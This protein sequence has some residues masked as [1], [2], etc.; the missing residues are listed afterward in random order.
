[1]VDRDPARALDELAELHAAGALTDAEFTAARAEVTGRAAA[2]PALPAVVLPTHGP[3]PADASARRP[4]RWGRPLTAL[5]VA[6]VLVAA[7][8]LIGG[9]FGLFSG[10]GEIFLEATEGQG[11]DPFT[12]DSARRSST[13]TLPAPAD[14]PV[15]ADA[16]GVPSVRGGTPGIYG[17][18]RDTGQ[19]DRAQIVGF[20]A[21][22]PEK[23]AAWAGVQGITVD[24]IPA[25]VEQLTPTVLLQDT[26]V[27]N[28]GFTDGRAT[29]RQS[30]LQAGTAVLVDDRGVPRVRCACGNPLVAP[31][32][33]GV[34]PRYQNSPWN[35]FS[36]SRLSVIVPQETPVDVFTLVD[37]QTG[38]RFDRPRGSDGE[39]DA[40]TGQVQVRLTWRGTAD[41][42]LYVT[43]PDGSTIYY[44]ASSSPSGGTLDVDANRGCSTGAIGDQVNIENVYWPEESA[45]IGSYG[46]SASLYSECEGPAPTYQLTVTVGGRVVHDQTLTYDYTVP[47]IYFDN[48]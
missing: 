28:H 35:G 14:L 29:P 13:T 43:E 8:L 4:V 3:R 46:A 23:A 12:P 33:T 47:T 26:R 11:G 1:M 36:E 6:L 24:G 45:P 19:C 37:L 9:G 34:T 20:L 39:F 18:D 16:T 27:T 38:E 48:S 21:G 42:D 41:L 15:A 40:R 32:P 10:G 30:V 22:E 5:A 44:G 25:F 31:Q 2:P 7:T 17:G